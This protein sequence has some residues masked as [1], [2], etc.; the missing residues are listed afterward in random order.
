MPNHAQLDSGSVY[1]RLERLADSA[2]SHPV[3]RNPFY[4][5][6]TK[7]RLGGEA[8]KIFRA[9]YTFRVEATVGRLS[10]AL[11][12]IDDPDAQIKLWENLG[13]ELGHGAGRVHIR[14]FDHWADNLTSRLQPSAETRAVRNHILDATKAFV[15]ET[16]EMCERDK[17]SAA[18]A[19]LAQEWHGYTQIAFLYDG[20]LNYRGL[21]VGEEFHDVAEYFYVHIGCAEKQHKIQAIEIAKLVCMT[22]DDCD[23]VEKSFLRYLDL[24]EKFWLA[25]YGEISSLSDEYHI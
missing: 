17:F 4:Q 22:N 2:N 20:Y 7:R 19:I 5:L 8:F 9:N 23:L 25:V 1:E 13:D 18:G 21:F 16:N 24:L 14:L 11:V 15:V 10:R 3:F 12:T 6:W